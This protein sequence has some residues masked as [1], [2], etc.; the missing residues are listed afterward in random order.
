M[1]SLGSE[2]VRIVAELLSVF[3]AHRTGANNFIHQLSMDGM[4]Q[5]AQ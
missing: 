5:V 3:Q 2:M 1:L 4:E